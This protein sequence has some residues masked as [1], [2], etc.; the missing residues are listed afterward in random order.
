M[1]IKNLVKTCES[2]FGYSPKTATLADVSNSYV[3]IDADLFMY[4]FSYD[5]SDFLTNFFIMTMNLFE[6]TIVPIFV[7]GGA[8]TS[9]KDEECRKRNE[10]KEKLKQNI[11]TARLS[12]NIERYNN[13]Q[14]L[15][16][17]ITTKDFD[18]LQKLLH[19][20]CV[21]YLTIHNH[22]S[23]GFCAWLNKRGY[24]HHVITN[25]SDIFAYG[26]KSVIKNYS[27][28][29][30]FLL[31]DGDKFRSSF[32]YDYRTGKVCNYGFEDQSKFLDYC[33]LL[34]T[35]FNKPCLGP[36]TAYR[37]ICEL[38]PVES[39]MYV[40]SRVPLYYQIVAEYNTEYTF[41]TRFEIFKQKQPHE[42]MSMITQQIDIR[43]IKALFSQSG[44][45]CSTLI[46]RFEN[47]VLD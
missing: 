17:D 5:K 39:H 9:L 15:I 3:S 29:Y 34:G 31:Y 19:C 11:E 16:F 20:L 1:G 47:N 24:C 13:L 40:A 36:K 37:S 38:S 41:E 21:P 6:H 7:F 26:A 35:D 23:E 33:I 2:V 4:N 43:E 46:R 10:R 14:K 45:S 18:L 44:R 30:P 28:G 27:N 32:N 42:L 12:G 8:R 25:D 22:E